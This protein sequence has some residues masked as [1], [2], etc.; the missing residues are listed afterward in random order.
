M[1]R[2]LSLVIIGLMGALL[3]IQGCST[4]PPPDPVAGIVVVLGKDV[5]LDLV[6]IPAGRFMMGFTEKELGEL[7]EWRTNNIKEQKEEARN[8]IDILIEIILGKKQE[9]LGKTGPDEVDEFIREYGKQ[10][11]VTITKPFYMGKFEVTQEQWESVMG[12]NPSETKGVKLPVTDVSWEDCQD[13]IKKLNTKTD[14]G[15]RLPT[16]AEWEY[17]CRA[18]TTTKYSFG[19]KI[20]RKDANYRNLTVETNPVAVG[21]YKPNAFGL[22]DMHGN[23]SEWCEDW[24]GNYPSESV[25]D[26]K[27]SES[28]ECRVVRGGCWWR[29]GSFV[30]SSFRD[31]LQPS[32]QFLGF[33]FRL[34][35]MADF[36]V[37]VSPTSPKPDPVNLLLAPFTETQAKEIQK[38]IAKSFQKEVEEKA[39]LGKGINLDLVLIPAGKFMMGSPESEKGQSNYVSQYEAMISKPFYMG[40]YEVTQDQWDA[41]MNSN[42]SNKKGVNL[43]VTNL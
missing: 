30:R 43:P 20:T 26:P 21:S 31:R 14:G 27:G 29:P 1:K 5:N 15:Y 13:F 8:F 36:K 35:R 7:K 40:K 9:P 17:A 28:G 4:P 25:T 3:V 41:V 11:E 32:S 19:D 10:H 2:F 12:N 23:A 39:D 42:P 6:L 34:A 22:Y 16:E 24:H 37:G 38:V 33:G 18:G